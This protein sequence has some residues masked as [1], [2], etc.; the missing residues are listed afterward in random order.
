MVL[1]GVRRARAR[2]R[3]PARRPGPGA[4]CTSIT[5]PRSQLEPRRAPDGLR[6]LRAPAPLAGRRAAR[7]RPSDS[8]IRSSTYLCAEN[9]SCFLAKLGRAG[10][11]APW[12]RRP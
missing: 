4:R 10:L 9:M 3:A 2:A 6:P 11:E 8:E 1:R 12:P 7:V 5:R